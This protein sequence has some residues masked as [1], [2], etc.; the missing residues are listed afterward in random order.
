MERSDGAPSQFALMI[1]QKLDAHSD[2]LSALRADVA[3]MKGDIRGIRS[4]LDDMEQNQEEMDARIAA[5]EKSALQAVPIDWKMLLKIVV[6]LGVVI[7]AAGHGAP[8][9]IWK[10]LI[11]LMGAG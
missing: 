1:A 2:H 6:V 5:L 8:E 7:L 4:K 10:A 11:R 3:E 9:D